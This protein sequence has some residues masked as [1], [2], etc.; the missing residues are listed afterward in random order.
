MSNLSYLDWDVAALPLRCQIEG[1]IEICS[2][3]KRKMRFYACRD[4]WSHVH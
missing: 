4:V 1:K 3:M 2:E